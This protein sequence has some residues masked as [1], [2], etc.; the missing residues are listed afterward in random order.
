M[1]KRLVC[2]LVIIALCLTVFAGCATAFTDDDLSM[3]LRNLEA[4]IR[5]KT[6]TTP[7]SYTVPNVLGE[8]QNITDNKGN[9]AKIYVKWEVKGDGIELVDNGDTTTVVIPAQRS[10]NITYTLK[11]TLVNESGKDYRTFDNKTF[12]A[13]FICNTDATGSGGGQGGNGGNNQGDSGQGGNGGNQG[14]DNQGGGNQGGG[15]GDGGNGGNQG[16]EVTGTLV[17][18]DF[19]QQGFANAEKVTTVTV[20]EV[21]CAFAQDKGKN[22]PAYY[23]EGTAVRFYSENTLTISGATI[24]KMVFT[25]DSGEKTIGFTPDKGDYSNNVWTGSATSVVFTGGVNEAGAF[26]GHKRIVKIEVIIEEGSNTGSGSGG[27]QG[28]QGG[29]NQGDSGN[30]GGNQGSG[31]VNGNVITID[32]SQQGYDNEQAINS[33]ITVGDITLTFDKGTGSNPPKYYTTG[34]AVRF[35]IGNTLTIS[36]AAMV[37]IVFT[38]DS[39]EKTIGF[40][41]DNGDYSNNTWTGSANSVVFTGGL[42]GETSGHKR[43]VKVEITVEGNGN[44]GDGGNTGENPGTG[45]TQYTIEFQGAA[46][47]T[48]TLKE[49]TLQSTYE[50][51]TTLQFK[52]TPNT[53]YTLTSVKLQGSST[54]LTADSEGYYSVTITANT[55]VVVTLESTSGGGTEPEVP[56]GDGDEKWVFVEDASSL[57]AGDKIVLVVDATTQIIAGNLNDTQFTQITTGFTF[58]A[59]GKTIETL[60]ANALVLKLGGQAGAWTLAN[61]NKESD[62][63]GQSSVTKNNKLQWGGSNTTWKI[64]IYSSAASYPVVINAAGQLTGNVFLG[65]YKATDMVFSNLKS[66]SGDAEFAKV[67]KLTTV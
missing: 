54:A 47:A 16:G 31:T 57:K 24:L 7:E 4:D 28:G 63:L 60:P 21:T 41:P 29:D 23:T 15:Q 26:S 34:T 51:G 30:Q 52:V 22:P 19:T 45:G 14:G 10:G 13:T 39:G 59:D 3:A 11:A 2:C 8:A 44:T 32:F 50:S 37:K 55:I 56:G 18:F 36:G 64:E 49:G 25:F 27:G 48:I 1:K 61:S 46:N 6:E 42:D 43:I 66:N 5:A 58:S 20:D 9:P 33:A 62:L 17:T 53:G 67:Y 12:T 38:F 35:Y 65:R 40:T